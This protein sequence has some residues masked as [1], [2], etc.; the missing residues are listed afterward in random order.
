MRRLAALARRRSQRPAHLL[1]GEHGER[2]AIFY[3]R[4]RGYV[5]VARRWRS[6]KLR[7]DLDLVAWDSGTLCVLEIK[8][9]SQRHLVAA[10]A[11]VDTDKQTTLLRLAQAYQRRLPAAAQQAPI[12]FDILSVY[13][14]SDTHLQPD[15]EPDFA[16]Y[17]GAF[18]WK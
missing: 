13:L 12:R 4:R 5:V 2:E 17:Q 16:L 11:A 1:T 3:L 10:E 14:P 18:S 9:R 15:S 6:A 7:G 8:T